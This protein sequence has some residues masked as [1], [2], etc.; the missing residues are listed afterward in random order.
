MHLR[1]RT[2]LALAL[3]LV[4]SG[5]FLMPGAAPGGAMGPQGGQSAPTQA[6]ESTSAPGGAAP[7]THGLSNSNGTPSTPEKPKPVSMSIDMKNE[8][9]NTVHLFFG[10][11]PG[12]SSGRS[13]TLGSNT[14]SSEGRDFDGSLMI[15]V[16]DD[17]EH[18]L[19]SVK[20]A[21][22]QRKA[23]IGSDC[24]SIHAE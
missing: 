23:T 18:G 2:A 21:P 1:L 3:P 24:K 6:G 4:L 15:W 14:L 5:C 7:S 9:P 22:S 19:A 17:H 10:E 20:V 11:K 16:T 12:F 8:C 13:S